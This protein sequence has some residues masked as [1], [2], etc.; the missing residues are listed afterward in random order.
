MTAFKVGDKVLVKHHTG[1][2]YYARIIG[3]LEPGR[4][5]THIWI[6][7]DRLRR[8]VTVELSAMAHAKKGYQPDS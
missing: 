6:V 7:R 4:Y 8:K 2:V 5:E 3:R 1:M